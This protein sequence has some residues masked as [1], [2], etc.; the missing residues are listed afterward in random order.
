MKVVN[1]TDFMN[2]SRK[3]LQGKNVL[4]KKMELLPVTADR[5]LA[6]VNEEILYRIEEFL[7]EHGVEPNAGDLQEIRAEAVEFIEIKIDDG[8]R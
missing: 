7:N 2:D 6:M 8:H 5:F 3:I 4:A 1:F